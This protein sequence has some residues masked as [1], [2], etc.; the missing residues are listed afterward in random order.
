MEGK[1]TLTHKKAQA[2]AVLAELKNIYPEVSTPLNHTT[3]FE[4][5]VA[6]MLSAQ[7]TDKMV[8]RVTAKL[9][10]KYPTLQD[11]CGASVDTFAQD[12]SSITFYKT[13]ARHI[14]QAANIIHTQYNGKIPKTMEE[15]LTLPGVG[16]KTANVILTEVFD[17]KVGIVVD[18]H[19]IRI[20]QLLG[21]TSEKVA[22]KI[23]QDLMQI[24]PYTSWREYS[25][26]LIYYGRE[27]WPA[28]RPDTGPLQRYHA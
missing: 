25:L 19:V 16:R 18:T 3:H 26:M 22:E 1:R 13:K 28:R 9:F 5:L 6:V 14:L 10:K 7:C 17:K 21:L 20:S 12:I 2:K 11:Y 27:Y 24:I 8:N 15:L 4:L 23:E